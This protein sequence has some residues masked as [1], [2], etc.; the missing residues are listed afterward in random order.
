MKNK[1]SDYLTKYFWDARDALVWR[2]VHKQVHNTTME[3]LKSQPIEATV[4]AWIKGNLDIVENC[5]DLDEISE[6]VA[7]NM[8]HASIVEHLCYETLASYVDDGDVAG[9][10]CHQSVAQYIELS[11]LAGY[12]DVDHEDLASEVN[13]SDL[14]DYIDAEKLADNI[15]DLD[16]DAIKK[17]VLE[18]IS[19]KLGIGKLTEEQMPEAMYMLIKHFDYETFSRFVITEEFNESAFNH[20]TEKVL[21]FISQEVKKAMGIDHPIVEPPAFREDVQHQ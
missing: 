7:D 21:D 16:S 17:E 18:T 19:Q 10:M 4:E 20:V 12:V 1:F 14:A 9:N 15:D 6:N 5:I 13:L 3:F 11:E 2:L 8:S